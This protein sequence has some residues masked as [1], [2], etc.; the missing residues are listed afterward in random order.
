MVDTLKLVVKQCVLNQ[1]KGYWLLSDA[2]NVAI[3]IRMKLRVN[4]NHHV[5]QVPP[6]AYG[7][8]DDELEILYGHIVVEKVGVLAPFLSFLAITTIGVHDRLALMLDSRF[9][10]LKCVIDFLGHGKAKL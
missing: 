6:L 10:G 5:V 3:T 1:T 2:L 4:Y 8:I 9:K 7:T